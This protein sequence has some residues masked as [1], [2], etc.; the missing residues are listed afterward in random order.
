M[1]DG[2]EIMGAVAASLRRLRL[3]RGLSLNELARQSSVAKAT[4]AQLELGRGNPTVGTLM[5]LAT[6]L[7][8]MLTDLISPEA[9]PPV[10]VIRASEGTMVR[11]GGLDL[12]LVHRMAAARATYEI[13][14]MRLT[15][16]VY[17]SPAHGDGVMEHLMV[18]D[19][20][21][22]VGP[23][24]DPVKLESGDFISFSADRPHLY[25]TLTPAARATLIVFYPAAPAERG[26][27]H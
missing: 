25:Q 9:V 23:K 6:S 21:L 20:V 22:L 15:L 13:Y 19:G 11:D 18:H 24:D 14:D 10:R 3:A 7:G 27:G 5:S 1:D 4:L 8:V 26:T 17:D 2:A 16:G 12:R